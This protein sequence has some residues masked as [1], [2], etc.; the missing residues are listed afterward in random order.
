M[1]RRPFAII[2][3]AASLLFL[4]TG[5]TARANTTTVVTF[6]EEFINWADAHVDTFVMPESELSFSEVILTIVIGC[7]G[8]PGD[9]DPWDRLGYL[10][11]LRQNG[12][13]TERLEIARFITP[14]DITGGGGPGTCP[15]EY[16]VTDYL[17]ILKDT[18]IFSLYIESWIG[19]NE[20][21]LITATFDFVEGEPEMLPYRVEPLWDI[22]RLVYGDPDN[23]PE[24]HL[25]I[26]SVAVDDTTDSITV[27]ITT[28]G[29]GQGNTENAAEFSRQWHGVWIDIDYFQHDLWRSDC[30][31]NPCSPQGGTWPYDRAGWCP[32]DKVTPWDLPAMQFSSAYPLEVYYVLEPY[33]NDCRPT[34]PDCTPGVTCTDCDY[35]STGHTEPVYITMAQA[36]LYRRMDTAADPSGGRISADEF[37]LEQ[38][39]PNPFNSV[40]EIAFTL[41]HTAQTTL[42]IFDITGRT[43]ATLTDGPMSS[44]RHTV[45]FDAKNLSTGVYLYSLRSGGQ[46]LTGKMLYIK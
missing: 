36:I 34:N 12:E 30:E 20:G 9:C 43:V 5:N 2:L 19:G 45:R 46:S 7:P 27:R 31:N 4:L 29:H 16:D 44:G 40:T 17:P 28:T 15:W 11:V 23:P 38:N 10:S 22:G 18:V 42:K 13:E 41:P 21:W 25:P 1:K 3:I 32:G 35:N 33:E 24:D 6:D 39:Y 8:A 14:Y 26:A 37:T